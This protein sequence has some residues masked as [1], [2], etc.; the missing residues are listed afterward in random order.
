MRKHTQNHNS[1][2]LDHLELQLENDDITLLFYQDF[3]FL[4][5]Y[6]YDHVR[7]SIEKA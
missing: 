6:I 5:W 4:M 7:H 2:L 1:E 3:P